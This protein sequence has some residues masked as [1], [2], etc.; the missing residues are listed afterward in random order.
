MLIDARTVPDGTTLQADICVIGAG[1]AGITVARAFAGRRERMVVLESGGLKQDP[2]TDALSAGRVVGRPYFRLEDTRARVLGGTTTLW[3]GECRPLDSR[4]FQRHDWLPG[5]GWPFGREELASWY[6]AARDTFRLGTLPFEADDWAAWGVSAI[7]SPESGLRTDAFHYSPLDFGTTYRA[8]LEAA[9]NISVCLHAVV[10]ELETPDPPRRVRT[11]RV[12]RDSGGGFRV[13]ARAFVLAAGGIENPRLLLM[14]GPIEAGGIGN[15]SGLVG[16]CFMEHLYMD[17]AALLRPRRRT[18]DSFYVTGRDLGGGRVRGIL[19]L[20]PEVRGRDEVTN[21]CAVVTEL[22]GS[23]GAAT[24]RAVLRS[25][26]RRRRLPVAGGARLRAAAVHLA[27]RRRGRPARFLG[28]KSV[29][30]QA[31]NPDSRLTLARERDR[32]GCPVV[33][34]DWRLSQV[35]RRAAVRAQALFHEGLRRA[36][37]GFAGF[38]GREDEPWP[39][40]LRGAR[41]HM[42]TTRMHEDPARGVVDRD[43]KVHGLANLYVAG[44]SCFPTSGAAN[45]T[46]T[47]V[48]LA[49]R[50][51]ERLR[52]ALPQAL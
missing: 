4:D 47:I 22:P 1:P 41:H 9:P 15:D 30:E 7:E 33:R 21:V 40:R 28:L 24:A 10:A 27:A 46:F 45:P 42:G 49:L 5:S 43:G 34:L 35:D 31:P 19:A 13:E 23:F 26:A 32:F 37:I 44:S 52:R 14:S 25:L 39:E 50:L 18:L 29:M 17:E 20:D 51:A 16:R 12:V 36:G 11:A 38:M 2:R 48:A 6:D 3:A 8:E